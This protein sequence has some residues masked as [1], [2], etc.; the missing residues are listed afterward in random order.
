MYVFMVVH[1]YYSFDDEHYDVDI[2]V[3]NNIKDAKDYFFLKKSNI[4][5]EHF[6]VHGVNTIAEFLQSDFCY[7]DEEEFVDGEPYLFIENEHYGSDRLMIV[8]KPI[9][10]FKES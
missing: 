10:N 8:Q 3:F 7:C 2:D 5:D 4:V 6:E 1:Q 9:M